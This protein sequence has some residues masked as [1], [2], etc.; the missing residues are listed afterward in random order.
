MQCYARENQVAELNIT[1]LPYSC[2]TLPPV[3]NKYCSDCEVIVLPTTDSP[4]P[5]TQPTHTLRP[6][7]SHTSAFRQS[8]LPVCFH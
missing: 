8:Q 7:P 6:P 3:R 2:L 1:N 5:G 4:R